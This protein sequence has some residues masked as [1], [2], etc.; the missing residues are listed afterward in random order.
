MSLYFHA[1]H[2][3]L[4]LKL[5]PNAR[6]IAS[7]IP[8]DE[9]GTPMDHDSLRTGVAEFALESQCE[10]VTRLR[11]SYGQVRRHIYIIYRPAFEISA[12][13]HI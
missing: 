8:V 3:T 11:E 10:A 12:H 13:T 4:I 6:A 2:G 5:L 1:M 7:Q 9:H